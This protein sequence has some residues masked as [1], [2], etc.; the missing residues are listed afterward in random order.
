MLYPSTFAAGNLEL[1]DPFEAPYEVV[2]LSMVEGM[3]RLPPG[4]RLRPWI[5]YY[6]YGPDKHRLQI[7]AVEDAGGAGWMF[8]NGSSSFDDPAGFAD[9]R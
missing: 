4:T 9:S 7:R 1:E 5:Q 2:H 3:R 6:S 8:W